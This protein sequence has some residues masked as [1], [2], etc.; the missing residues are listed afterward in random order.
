MTRQNGKLAVTVDV[1][2]WYHHLTVTGSPYAEYEDVES[3]FDD[4]TGRYDYVSDPCF[5][6]LDMLD[7]LD[8]TATF[9]VVADLIDRSPGLVEE[10][11]ARGHRIA[12]H[13]LHHTSA[14]HPSTKEPWVEP[15]DFV[16]RIRTAKEK[17]ERASGQDV[18][19]FRAPNAY[20]SGWMIDR[21]EALGFD[22]DSSVTKNSLYNKTDS[23]LEEVGSEP[24]EPEE[25]RLVPGG[26]RDI[27]EFPWPYYEI[28]GYRIPTAGGPLIRL[29]GRRIVQRGIE[30]SL[31]RGDTMFYFHPLDISR[32]SL[33]S[34]G[35]SYRRPAYWAFKGKRTERRIRD[36]L[37]KIGTD[38]NATVEEL[39][40]IE[41]EMVV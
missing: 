37:S 10:I 41:E 7:D 39:L 9:F 38:S 35:T 24:F 27:A 30:Q 36:L 26:N 14:L 1:E 29:F 23:S 13:G 33:P 31:Q 34:V 2:D 21:L 15:P 28:G 25:G 20:I 4:W 22:Y 3:F 40:H 12:C 18:I 5:R 16:E 32:E 17:L 8:I 6:V 19:G 11:A